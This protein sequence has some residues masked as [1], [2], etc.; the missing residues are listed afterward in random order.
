MLIYFN[1]LEA[2][3]RVIKCSLILEYCTEI[4]HNPNPLDSLC[5][6][7]F[8]FSLGFTTINTMISKRYS[9]FSDLKYAFIISWIQGY[10]G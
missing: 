9:M 7:R 1:P 8:G 10:S 6:M 4:L 2:K 5:D 3:Q